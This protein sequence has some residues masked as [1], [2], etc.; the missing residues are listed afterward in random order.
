MG[1]VIGFDPGGAGTFGWCVAT[2]S[3]LPLNIVDRN[4]SDHAEGACYAAVRAAE[5][6]G[7]VSAVGIDAPLF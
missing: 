6:E 5:S 7:P 4:T 1:V 2:G 3:A